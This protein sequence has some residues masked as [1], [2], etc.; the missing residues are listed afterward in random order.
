[1]IDEIHLHYQQIQ[2]GVEDYRRIQTGF[3]VVS[4]VYICTYIR[5][6][7][8]VLWA[9]E[10]PILLDRRLFKRTRSVQVIMLKPQP[11][12]SVTYSKPRALLF[13]PPSPYSLIFTALVRILFKSSPWKLCLYPGASLWKSHFG[14]T[15]LCNLC[16]RPTPCWDLKLCNKGL[17]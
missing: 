12:N 6:S 17:L 15:S 7:L 9:N 1:L 14:G 8:L 16:I 4:H 13:F 11:L 3:E 10:R 5:K 2:S